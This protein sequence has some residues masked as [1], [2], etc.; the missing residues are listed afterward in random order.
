MNSEKGKVESKS[1]K[2][3]SIKVNGEW[4]STFKSDDLNHINWKDN[5]EFLWDYDKSGEYRNIKGVVTAT[6][7]G[8]TGTPA[9]GGYNPLGVEVGHA[10]NSAIQVALAKFDKKCLATDDFYKFVIEQT[11]KIYTINKSIKEN[12]NSPNKPA[13]PKECVDSLPEVEDLF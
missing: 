12:I 6:A 9:K 2:G 4:Y 1:R 10:W 8:D 13:P 7:G 5:V 3:N 11:E